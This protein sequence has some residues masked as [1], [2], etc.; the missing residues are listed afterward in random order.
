MFKVNIDS[1]SSLYLSTLQYIYDKYNTQI[2]TIDYLEEVSNPVFDWHTRCYKS[3]ESRKVLLPSENLYNLTFKNENIQVIIKNITKENGDI[4]KLYKSD[5]CGNG[6]DELYFK[7]TLSSKKSKDLLINF[8]DEAK[9]YYKSILNLSKNIVDN[10]IRIY[11]WK[12]GYWALLSK[13]PKRDLNTIYLRE[14]IKEDLINKMVEFYDINTRNEYLQHGVPYKLVNMLYGV[15]GSGKTSLINAIASY[16]SADIYTIPITKELTDLSLIDSFTRMH[17]TNDDEK[18]KN[19]KIIVIED[20]DCI[21][22]ERKKGDDNNM[23]TLNGLLNCLDGFTCIEGTVL[24]LTANKPESL[25]YALIRSCRIDNK[26][27]L[28]Y[29]DEYQTKQMFD[30]YFKNQNFIKFYKKISHLEYSTA[31]LQEFFFYNRKCKNIIDKLNLFLE[32]IKNNKP[33]ELNKQNDKGLY[34]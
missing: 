30:S 23:L 7:I 33:D 10:T 28:L 34:N 31:M 6:N 29:C 8:V 5:S 19:K 16:F 24:F 15:P 32:I 27:N 4:V 21:F 13:N 3:K 26:I 14:N 18:E 12:D 2:H 11:Y 20:I 17:H 25:D 22:T 1:T 9:L